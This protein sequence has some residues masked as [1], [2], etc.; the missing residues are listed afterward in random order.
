[1][2]SPLPYPLPPHKGAWHRRLARGVPAHDQQL[3][4]DVHERLLE[5]LLK[6]QVLGH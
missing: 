5:L 3:E 6:E 4:E 1:M 2:S